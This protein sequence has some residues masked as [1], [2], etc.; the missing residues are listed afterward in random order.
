MLKATAVRKCDTSPINTFDQANFTAGG[1]FQIG[2]GRHYPENAPRQFY[3]AASFGLSASLVANRESHALSRRPAMSRRR[4]RPSMGSRAAG[5]T[6]FLQPQSPMDIGLASGWRAFCEGAGWR[7]SDS[8]YATGSEHDNHPVVELTY[9]DALAYAGWVG[10][11]LPTEPEWEIATSLKKGDCEFPW[12]NE[13]VPAN[14]GQ[15]KLWI[16]AFPSAH[17]TGFAS[18]GTLSEFR[19]S[20]VAGDPDMTANV[21]Q[22]TRPS[23]QASNRDTTC[24]RHTEGVDIRVFEN[25][26]QLCSSSRCPR[27]RPSARHP[28]DVS[29]AIAHTGFRAAW[30]DS[31]GQTC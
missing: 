9:A 21:R 16:E 17:Q 24:C 25:E 7:N 20:N 28:R 6:V 19:Y 4:K 27:N 18:R 22:W 12:E 23:D 3:C 31:E 10:D 29:A 15:A 1:L 26:L 11:D 30:R 5:S 8:A 13:H 14:G 2:S